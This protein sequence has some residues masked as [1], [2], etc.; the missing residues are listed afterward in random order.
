M[1]ANIVR[2]FFTNY[3]M[4]Y[5]GEP[6]RYCLGGIVFYSLL[7]PKTGWQKNNSFSLFILLPR[8]SRT[9]PLS[10]GLESDSTPRSRS[11]LRYSL[12]EEGLRSSA[13]QF[14]L[15]LTDRSQ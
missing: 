14:L 1:L 13:S 15:Y 10:A 5:G 4:P 3:E 12:I 9:S 6:R 7:P 2:Y 8:R 11:E